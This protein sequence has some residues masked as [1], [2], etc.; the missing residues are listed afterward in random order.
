MFGTRDRRFEN[1]MKSSA[2]VSEKHA[3]DRPAE[4]ADERISKCTPLHHRADVATDCGKR[5]CGDLFGDFAGGISSFDLPGRGFGE[6]T[7]LRKS[8]YWGLLVVWEAL[9]SIDEVSPRQ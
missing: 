7:C 6:L 4:T 9:S 1:S 2:S 5:S 8:E 3:A